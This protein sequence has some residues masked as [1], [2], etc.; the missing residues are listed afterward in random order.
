MAP[1]PKLQGFEVN[2]S[3]RYR[4][5]TFAIPIIWLE[6]VFCMASLIGQQNIKLYR[7]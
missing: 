1:T 5:H 3:L 6:T 4:V 2:T 7:D